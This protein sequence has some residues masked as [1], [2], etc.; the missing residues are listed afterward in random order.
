[1]KQF[2]IKFKYVSIF[3]IGTDGNLSVGAPF[4]RD[5]PNKT[6]QILSENKRINGPS[7]S[8][9]EI[10]AFKNMSNLDTKESFY[11][12][13]DLL[14]S[15]IQA[16]QLGKDGDENMQN[17]LNNLRTKLIENMNQEEK[18]DFEKKWNILF[19]MAKFG[20]HNYDVGTA[21]I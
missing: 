12:K 18:L 4:C 16:K 3:I 17:I 20:I 21:G 7:L 8:L 2:N 6:V 14:K 10:A 15:A 19:N 9:E 1:M 5:C 11:E 13:F